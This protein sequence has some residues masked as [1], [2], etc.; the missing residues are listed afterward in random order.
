MLKL[1]LTFGLFTAFAAF[2]AGRAWCRPTSTT[3]D[4]R[5]SRSSCGCRSSTASTC[6]GRATSRFSIAA[7]VVLIALAG[8]SAFSIGLHRVRAVHALLFVTAMILRVPGRAS[9]SAQRTIC[10]SKRFDV[11]RCRRAEWSARDVRSR[12]RG[13]RARSSITFVLDVHGVHLPAASAGHPARVAA[14]LVR[15]RATRSDGFSGQVARP[16]SGGGSGEQGSSEA[17]DPDNYFGYGEALN[18]RAR[19]TLSDDLVMRV[20]SPRPSLY[21]AQGY[22]MYSDGRWTSSDTDLEEVTA[23]VSARSVIP[24]PREG[25]SRGSERRADV[26]R[27]AASFR[28]SCSTRTGPQ[29]VFV[30]ETR[31]RVDD[32]SSIRLPFTL[33]VDTIYSVISDV[34]NRDI[35]ELRFA[36]PS[37]SRHRSCSAICRSRR[38]VG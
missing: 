10:P 26:L 37:T 2:L 8:S 29:Q 5:W 30:A 22:D 11:I 36:G 31:A 35:D 12:R 16:S 19:G 38:H 24:T 1:V 18:L 28:T 23:A 4:A 7:S 33:D 32:F 9:G 27:R 25:V 6:P 21:R 13:G 3:P 20:R 17:F 34:R 14:V 15:E